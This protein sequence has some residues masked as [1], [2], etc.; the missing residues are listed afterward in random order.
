V[1]IL[2]AGEAHINENP[3]WG[4]LVFLVGAALLFWAG[5]SAFERWKG[6]DEEPL[7]P[8]SEASP[9]G[10]V[11]SQVSDPAD[12][13]LTPRGRATPIGDNDLDLFVETNLERLPR[14]ELKRQAMSLFRKSEST[15][16]RRI[17]EAREAREGV[18]REDDES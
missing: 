17:R 10:G 11:K 14:N 2:A 12:P 4:K 1:I 9:Q 18:L 5:K 13:I 16:K 3:G 7:S 8:T 15:I 6:L